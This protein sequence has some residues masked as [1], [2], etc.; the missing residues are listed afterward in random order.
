MYMILEKVLVNYGRLSLRTVF[1]F[2]MGQSYFFV[3]S[4]LFWD[5]T[6][7]RLVVSYQCCSTTYSSHLQ[8]IPGTVE[9]QLC[10]ELYEQ[11]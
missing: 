11:Q 5:V 7:C 3:R 2:V 1:E 10:R 4:S 9:G 6:Q 8:R